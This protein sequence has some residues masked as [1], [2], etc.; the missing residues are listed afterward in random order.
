LAPVHLILGDEHLLVQREIDAVIAEALGGP[1]TGFNFARFSAADGASGALETART[2]PMMVPRRV[3]LISEVEQAEVPLVDAVL[4]YIEHPSPS[5]VLVMTGRKLPPVKGGRKLTPRIKKMGGQVKR[6]GRER[7]IPF[8]RQHARAQG[9]DLTEPAAALLVDFIGS[10]LTRLANEV[11]KAA[12][13]VGGSGTIGEA[14][15]AALCSP[16][17]EGE[18]WGLT[19]AIVARDT[20]RA[21]TATHRLMG[22]SGSA[23]RLLAMITWQI[24]E[25][26]MLQGALRQ[27][28]S[29]P[30]SW[31]RNQRKLRAARARLERHP[32]RPA[33]ILEALTR[34]NRRLNSARVGE[35]RV[36]EALVLELTTG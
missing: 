33:P 17:S 18:I 29:P 11:D 24:R 6:W 20:D 15:I 28:R 26:L 5:T 21:L 8:A 3:V 16:A 35:R 32:M 23:H 9:C 13:Y 25:L 27:R 1:T 36:F 22:S 4:A 19:D 31:G 14:D 30:G 7:P 12:C 2:M 34:A 10:G